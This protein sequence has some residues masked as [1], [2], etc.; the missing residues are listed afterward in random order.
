[1]KFMAISFVLS[2]SL[3]PTVSFAAITGGVFDCTGSGGAGKAL[4]VLDVDA[5]TGSVRFSST[6]RLLIGC[7]PVPNPYSTG[8]EAINCSRLGLERSYIRVETNRAEKTDSV[9]YLTLIGTELT[10]LVDSTGIN[11]RFACLKRR[12]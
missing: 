12:R 5:R 9:V 1:M 8:G 11:F 6:G 4:L 10:R 2:L 3:L 7:V